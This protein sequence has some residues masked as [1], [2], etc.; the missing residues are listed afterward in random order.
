[1]IFASMRRRLI[2]FDI[3]G[4]LLK[5]MGLGRRSIEAAFRDHY[6]GDRAYFAGVAFHGR[7]DFDIIDEAI[8]RVPGKLA[9]AGSLLG[10]YLGHLRRE[11]DQGP[12]LVLPGVLDLL[13]RLSADG[14]VTLGLVTGNVRE[15]ARIKLE[16]DRL[17]GFFA[18]GA[19]GDDHRDRGEL[20]KIAKDRARAGRVNGFQDSDVYVVGDTS[21][22][23]RAARAANAVAV[24][25]ATGGHS[26]DELAA[27][28]P[29]HLLP[30]L[31]P[32]ATVLAA[33]GS[34]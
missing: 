15:G 20:V 18:F 1:M 34:S 11:V 13:G 32:S 30:S 28:R 2:L 25:V 19:F 9:D 21:S 33:F 14:S 5:P 3:D 27:E 10:R 6:G 31:E 16:R 12:S 29:D 26:M 4:T 17:G 23:V 24:A 8:A 22:D 7:T